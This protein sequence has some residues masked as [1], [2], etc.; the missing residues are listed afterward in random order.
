MEIPFTAP[1]Y[2]AF[3]THLEDSGIGAPVACDIEVFLPPPD[4]GP[5]PFLFALDS[6]TPPPAVLGASLAAVLGGLGVDRALLVV[7]G[8]PL[9]G[10]ATALFDVLES[11]LNGAIRQLDLLGVDGYRWESLRLRAEAAA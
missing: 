9:P 5:Q 1:A 7:H 6:D 8:V 10:W 11:S 4:D 2:D 3:V